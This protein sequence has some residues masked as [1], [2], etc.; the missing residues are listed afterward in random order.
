MRDAC[1]LDA[2]FHHAVAIQITTLLTLEVDRSFLGGCACSFT[3]LIF[4]DV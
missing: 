4:Y 3:F 2:P 1:I